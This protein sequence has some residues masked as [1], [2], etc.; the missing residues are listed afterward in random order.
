MHNDYVAGAVSMGMG[1]LFGRASVGGPS[2][3]TDTV[4]SIQRLEPDDLLK[5]AQLAF[6]TT[7]L[8]P[9]AVAGDRDASR[10]IPAIFQFFQPVEDNGYYPL[11]PHVSHYAAHC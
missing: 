9:P 7:D 4:G 5:V 10:V 1:I 11:L 3:M 6:G 2:R 8:Q